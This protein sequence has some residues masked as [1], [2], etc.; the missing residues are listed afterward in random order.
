MFTLLTM[1]I[2][3]GL[4]VPGFVAIVP[5]SRQMDKRDLGLVAFA[6][7]FT[8]AIIGFVS[9]IFGFLTHF[10]AIALPPLLASPNIFILVAQFNGLIALF[11]C[12]PVWQLD[13]KK[14]LN[15]NKVA[16]FALIA[17]NLALV[18]P[19]FIINP[20]FLSGGS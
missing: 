6:G 14:I 7:P 19:A 16:Y 4:I 3:I 1:V 10:G 9:L 5:M 8:N 17:A 18:I 12:I 11:N 20:S 15:W 13:G 2:G